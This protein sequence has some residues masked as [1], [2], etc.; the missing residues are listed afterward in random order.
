MTNLISVYDLEFLPNKKIS[1]Q[2]LIVYTALKNL[3]KENRFKFE[4]NEIIID[5]AEFLIQC[6]D[7]AIKL[8]NKK[9]NPNE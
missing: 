2:S 1:K 3:Q 5:F 4:Q 8:N 7:I 9:A 6:K